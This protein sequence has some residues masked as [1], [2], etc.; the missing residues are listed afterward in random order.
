MRWTIRSIEAYL[1]DREYVD[2]AVVPL[3]P[4]SW[5]S[6]VKATVEFG[7]FAALLVDGLEQQLRGRVVH[8]PPFTYLKAE[9]IELR[10]E[11]LMEWEHELKENGFK[12]VFFICSDPEWKMV[13]EKTANSIIWLPAVPLEYMSQENSEEILS[14]QIKQL[15]KI[16]MLKWQ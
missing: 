6:E 9:S 4:V 13:E 14:S 8:F 10:L 11:R 12:H 2:T 15:L 5:K 1:K 16:I 3:V 7:E